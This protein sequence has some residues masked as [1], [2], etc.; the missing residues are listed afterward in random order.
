LS[1]K[2]KVSLKIDV[3]AHIPLK[4]KGGNGISGVVGSPAVPS[5]GPAQQL[6]LSRGR[7][8]DAGLKI[9]AEKKIVVERS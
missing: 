1:L 6:N 3:R 8:D 5:K 9:R 7:G 4:K 2:K